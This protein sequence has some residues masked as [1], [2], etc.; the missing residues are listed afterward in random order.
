MRVSF[1]N[2]GGIGPPKELLVL[3]AMQVE[4]TRDRYVG[5]N[6]VPNAPCYFGFGSRNVSYGHGAVQRKIHTVNGHVG[7]EVISDDRHE[8][9]EA[10][11]AFPA[12][13]GATVN[14][15]RRVDADHLNI[16]VFASG[17]HKATD[18]A[19]LAVNEVIAFYIGNAPGSVFNFGITARAERAGFLHIRDHC[20][21]VGLGT[22]HWK[23][24]CEEC[25]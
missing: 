4:R 6:D 14:L 13:R 1:G 19:S 25:E 21:L 23:S 12:S 18:E 22:C 15:I 8:M 24:Q 11:S 17:M 7:F 20:Q 5:P 10:F 3:I 16:G 2:E 9:L